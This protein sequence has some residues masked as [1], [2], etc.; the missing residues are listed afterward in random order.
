MVHCGILAGDY[1]HALDRLVPRCA[2]A[3]QAACSSGVQ[4]ALPFSVGR[5]IVTWA[6]PL[7]SLSMG[8][9][10]IRSKPTKKVSPVT[11]RGDQANAGH[12]LR[13]D[14]PKPDTKEHRI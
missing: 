14:P 7:C 4:I 11:F 9:V 1:A 10:I 5:G 3:M 13:P 2:H 12:R 8:V 6:A